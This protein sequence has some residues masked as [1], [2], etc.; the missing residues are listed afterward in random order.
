MKFIDSANDAYVI[1]Y[2][3][4]IGQVYIIELNKTKG[5]E[6]I[7]INGIYNTRYFGTL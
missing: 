2:D 7:D 5:I 4:P 6:Y 1:E 3:N